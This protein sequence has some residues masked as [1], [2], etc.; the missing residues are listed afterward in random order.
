MQRVRR[1]R[2][3]DV[4]QSTPSRVRR[5]RLPEVEESPVKARV[6]RV[7]TPVVE[8]PVQRP[9]RR[10]RVGRNT[11]SI[12][13]EKPRFMI[14]WDRSLGWKLQIYLVTSYHYYERCKSLITD[15]EY[16]RLCKELAAG[17]KTLQH[18]HKHCTDLGQLQAGTGYA[19]K[20]PRMVIG[21][22]EHMLRSFRE[23]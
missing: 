10:V 5:V 8:E 15:H 21:A 2:T 14:D 6:T 3:P 13:E 20:Y 9:T 18:Q 17:W 7:R 16:D 22:A 4:V 12:S 23:I 1:V 11:A 19:I